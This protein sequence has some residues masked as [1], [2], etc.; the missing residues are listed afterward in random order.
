MNIQREIESSVHMRL[1]TMTRCQVILIFLGIL[2]VFGIALIVGLNGPSVLYRH[3]MLASKLSNRPDDLSNGPFTITPP[4]LSVFNQELWLSAFINTSNVHKETGLVLSFNYSVLIS[5]FIRTEGNAT[6]DQNNLQTL[7]PIRHRQAKLSCLE[8]VCDELFLAHLAPIDFTVYS[9][10][11]HFDGLGGMHRGGEADEKLLAI[12]D[13]QFVY[14]YYNTAFTY[15]EMVSRFVCFFITELTT[16]LFILSLRG[17][18]VKDWSIEQRYTAFLLPSL[19]LYNNPFQPLK[20]ITSSWFPLYMDHVFQGTFLCT[21]LFFWLCVYHGM[22]TTRRKF[23]GFYLPKLII[24]GVLWLT[25]LSVAGWQTFN[26]YTD[27]TFNIYLSF[28]G[29]NYILALSICFGVIYFL[30]FAI[31]LVR[32]FTELRKLPYFGVRLKVFTA[33]S[34]LVLVACATALLFQFGFGWLFI[35]RPTV[36]PDA[37]ILNFSA[38]LDRPLSSTTVSNPWFHSSVEFSLLYAIFNAYAVA[39]AFIYSPSPDALLDTSFKD[40]PCVSMVNDS[41]EE[42]VY[43][44]DAEDSLIKKPPRNP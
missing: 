8:T 24:V 27:P 25:F 42:I 36:S 35:S 18:S 23:C 14:H 12:N 29:L 41:D 1:Y 40:D 30:F 19:M 15:L 17:F 20:F 7:M 16:V 22:R 31:L 39:L 11:I 37:R 2:M 9:F 6:L 28:K 43:E 5:I 3:T 38:D 34:I 26:E 13:V 21:L 4:P 10:T 32:A 33:L 44:S